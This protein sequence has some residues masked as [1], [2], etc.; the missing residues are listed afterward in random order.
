[1]EKSLAYTCKYTLHKLP[2]THAPQF[3][4]PISPLFH[5]RITK[6]LELYTTSRLAA[7]KD[8][9]DHHLSLHKNDVTKEE[10]AASMTYFSFSLEEFAREILDL[11][12][13]LS[14]LQTHKL[15]PRLPDYNWLAIWSH[16]ERSLRAPPFPFPMP[17]HKETPPEPA[18]K[19]A[20][21][22]HRIW[23]AL[24]KLRK[25]EVKFAFKVG[26]GAA[27]LA[28]PAFRERWREGFIHWRGEWALLSYFVVMANSVGATTASGIWRIVGTSLGAA[29]AIILCFPG[30]W[31]GLMVGGS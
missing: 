7:L 28:L 21:L 30:D 10:V 24:E 4:I 18:T 16:K 25:P 23:R 1:L 22:A 3:E 9:Y 15:H 11:I 6:A 20:A 5:E 8:L 13:V 29:A 31:V 26:V 19:K 12:S 14:D 17:Q 27:L 2:F